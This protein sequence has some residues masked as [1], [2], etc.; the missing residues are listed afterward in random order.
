MKLAIYTKGGDYF[1]LLDLENLL[2][3]ANKYSLSLSFNDEFATF[4]NNHYAFELNSYNDCSDI[5]ADYMVSFGGDGTFLHAVATMG[6][7]EI[8]IIGVNSGRLGFLAN[9]DKADFE[10][11]L[12]AIITGEFTIDK[13]AM[14]EVGGDFEDDNVYPY[15]FNEFTIQKSELNMVDISLDINNHRVLNIAADGMIVSTPSGSTAY[16]LSSGGAILSPDCH[17]FIITAIAPHNLT[18]RPIVVDE[19]SNITMRVKSRVDYCYATLDNRAYKIKSGATF[20]IK[21]SPHKVSLVKLHGNSFFE[22]LRKKLL[23][24]KENR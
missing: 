24:G 19:S 13:R 5:D 22:T 23:W 17:A 15:L 11:A 6:V 14:I 8:P 21:L 9:V 3:L 4:A 10:V 20:I 12:K 2:N 16:S 7:S 1:S 18:I